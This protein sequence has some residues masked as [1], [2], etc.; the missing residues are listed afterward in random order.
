LY[1][2][3]GAE[4]IC[5]HIYPCGLTIAP[6]PGAKKPSIEDIDAPK[7]RRLT[8]EN[9]P[10]TI[11][12]FSKTRNRD[13]SVNKAEELSK[14]LPWK[15]GLTLEIKEKG[16]DEKGLNNVLS[17]EWVPFHYDGILKTEKLNKDGTTTLASLLPK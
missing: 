2:W 14:P 11:R 7:L 16:T 1:S 10:V 15:F 4:I 6:K 13:L 3:E 17:Q 9:P 8:E 12:G 5:D